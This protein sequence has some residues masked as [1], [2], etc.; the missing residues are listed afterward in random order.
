M[1]VSDLKEED[2]K[3]GMRIRGLVSGKIGTIIRI[4]HHDDNYAWVSWEGED[5]RAG[6]YGNC[7]ECEVVE[8][9]GV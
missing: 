2:I 5:E 9:G 8:E 6:F 7:C 3:V 4:D 1:K